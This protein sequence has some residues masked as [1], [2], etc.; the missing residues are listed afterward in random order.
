MIS[1]ADGFYYELEF[2]PMGATHEPDSFSADEESWADGQT[3]WNIWLVCRNDDTHAIHE[4]LD[5][6]I[7]VELENTARMLFLALEEKIR[8]CN[9]HRLA[10]S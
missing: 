10:I 7:P 4:V 6:D 9:T 3:S 1:L 5:L 8:I 2:L